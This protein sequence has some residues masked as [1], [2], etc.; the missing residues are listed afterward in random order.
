MVVLTIWS[1]QRLLTK[2]ILFNA[3]D[4]FLIKMSSFEKKKKSLNF[5]KPLF[6]CFVPHKFETDGPV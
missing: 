2:K 3:F 5:V 6:Y 1:F 4:G